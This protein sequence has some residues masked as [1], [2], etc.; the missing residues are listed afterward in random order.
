M[1]ELIRDKDIQIRDKDIQIMELKKELEAV[2][3]CSCKSSP[4]TEDD[5]VNHD[6]SASSGQ[7]AQSL[8]S[9]SNQPDL[10]SYD[11]SEDNLHVSKRNFNTQILI[12]LLFWNFNGLHLSPWLFGKTRMVGTR[13]C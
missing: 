5:S 10:G 13:I 12:H 2:K 7:A 9:V 1:K 6:D 8:V 3:Y 11:A 4:I